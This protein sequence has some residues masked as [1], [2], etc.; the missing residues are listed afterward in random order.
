M[1]IRKTLA[2]VAVAAILTGAAA[3]AEEQP[4]MK[5]PKGWELVGFFAAKRCATDPIN[6]GDRRCVCRDMGAGK[7]GRHAGGL[8]RT[9]QSDL[10]LSKDQQ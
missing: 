3:V 5:C 6:S 9:A 1:N 7:K 10:R 8:L 2:A 4:E